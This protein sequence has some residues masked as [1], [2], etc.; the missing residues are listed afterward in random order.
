[1]PQAA[2]D[3]PHLAFT[4]HRIGVHDRPS[5]G[6]AAVR[7]EEVLRPFFDLSRLSEPDRNRSLGMGWVEVA[8]HAKSA[9]DRDH[10]LEQALVL[11]TRARTAG[12]RDSSLE[13]VLAGVRFDLRLDD[14]RP[15]AERALADPALGGEKRCN[16]L[17][18]IADAEL[19]QGHTREA[20]DV[21]RQLT[22]Y[23]R[24]PM[25]W[26]LLAGC[27]AE[28]GDQDAATAALETA[29]RI[30]PRLVS[31]HLQLAEHYRRRGDLQRAAWHQQ[32]AVP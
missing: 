13:A 12:L 3:I 20:R 21:L 2:T 10:Y 17:F 31:V 30:N 5:P 11:L 24:H 23:R 7:G 25:D 16:A 8:A 32:R 26:M 6:P 19:K 18:L 4:H 28:L 22:E 27:A 15:Y 29:V 9:A 14:S 1:M